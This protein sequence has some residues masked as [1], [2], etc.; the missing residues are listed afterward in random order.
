M[1]LG[2]ILDATARREHGRILAGL[3]RVCGDFDLAEE[4]LQD[5]YLKAA[6]IWPTTGIPD[7][8]AAWLSTVAKRRLI[9]LLR[10]HGRSRVAGD[11][12]EILETMAAPEPAETSVEFL[13]DDQ[14]RLIF[15]CCHPAL[16]P[17]ASIALALRTICGLTTREIARAFVEPEATTAQKLVRAKRKIADAKI[18][19]EIPAPDALPERLAAVFAV[20]YLLFNEG[21]ASTES[22]GLL[23]R[24]LCTEAIRLAKLVGKLLPG[25][26]E[27][28]ESEGLTALMLLHD[29][30][31]EARIGDDGELIPLEEQDRSRWDAAAIQEG[32]AVL[33]RAVARRAS[34]PYQLQAAIA[35]L[36]VQ[37]PTAAETDWTQITHLY[38][39]LLRLQ[40]TPVIEL[41]AAVALAMA[42]GIDEGIRWMEQI[43]RRGDLT[44]YHLLYAAR[45]DLNR[46]NHNEIAAAADY[47]RA[48]ELVRHAGERGYLQRRLQALRGST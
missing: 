13:D 21:Y 37:A 8:P 9:D 14:L 42:G 2:R 17:S 34:G 18:P 31:R 6:S 22:G 1:V 12:D 10:H 38:F 23:R 24:E 36:H 20:I 29:A 32:V 5:A 45:A 4:A 39:A 3:I 48:L 46:R 11:S 40:P 44:E 47:T 19:Y 26:S 25:S 16:A 7:S 15:T 30:R 33:D 27:S 41:N 43:E 28:A 35:A